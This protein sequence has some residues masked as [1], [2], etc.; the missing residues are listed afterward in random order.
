MVGRHI[1]NKS[2]ENIGEDW[3]GYMDLSEWT[4]NV[5]KSLEVAH[6]NPVSARQLILK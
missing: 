2:Q 6:V 3:H 4:A 1:K 5:D